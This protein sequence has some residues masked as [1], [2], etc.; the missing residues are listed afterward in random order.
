MLREPTFDSKARRWL[1]EQL[2]RGCSRREI[3]DILFQQ[4]FSVT[5]VREQMGASYPEP[6]TPSDDPLRPPPILSRPPRQLRKIDSP[7]LD[8]YVLDRLARASYAL[9]LDDLAQ[10]LTD[11]ESYVFASRLAARASP[12]GVSRNAVKNA[13]KRLRHTIGLVGLEGHV[14]LQRSEDAYSLNRTVVR[15]TVEHV[16]E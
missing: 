2:E 10:S 6:I 16:R 12:D 3:A 9:L 11:Y 7:K 4:G 8:L 15:I 13:I 14:V 5:T 1:K